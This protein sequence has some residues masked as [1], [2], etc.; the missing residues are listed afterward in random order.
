VAMEAVA[1][2]ICGYRS[3]AAAEDLLTAARPVDRIIE[4]NLSENWEVE[5]AVSKPGTFIVVCS[6]NGVDSGLPRRQLMSA[7]LT[8][9]SMLSY[10]PAPKKL[11]SAV[12][13]VEEVLAEGTLTMP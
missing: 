8:L 6:S 4:V 1:D 10:T 11:T 12:A 2:H 7:H 3:S 9:H 13:V 5:L